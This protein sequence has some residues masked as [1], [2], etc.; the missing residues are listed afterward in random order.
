MVQRYFEKFPIINYANNN[1]VDITKRVALI[2]RVS[3]NPYVF[4]PYDITDNERPD[5][6]S[7]RYYDDPYK[8]WLIYLSNKMLDPYY[9]WY[10]SETEFNEFLEKKYGSYETAANKIRHYKNDW[11]GKEPISSSVFNSLSAGQKKYWEP[12]YGATSQILSYKRKEV[13]WVS[14]TNKIVN[15]TVSANNNYVVDEICD[16]V[17]DSRNYGKGQVTGISGNSTVGYVSIHHL[18]GTYYTSNTVTISGS[19]YIYGNESG[20]NSIF[21]SVY[22]AANNIP[23]E[24]SAYWTPV[25]YY[26]YELARNEYNKNIRIMDASLSNAAA[27]NLKNLMKE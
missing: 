4:Y 22:S 6:I 9:E 21:T 16:I 14:N 23:E 13:D 17:F 5:Q 12:V 1:V 11:Q 20:T 10:L 25:T 15:Y 19:S 24:E 18:S 26:D 2:E 8:S 27:E 3:Q 7:T